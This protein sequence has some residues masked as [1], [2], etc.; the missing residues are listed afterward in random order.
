MTTTTALLGVGAAIRGDE[1]GP[2]GPVVERAIRSKTG[3]VNLEPSMVS[4]AEAESRYHQCFK[5][6]RD[7]R[8]EFVVDTAGRPL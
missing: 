1:E 6:D 4:A 5:A 2:G 8:T 3:S 7:L